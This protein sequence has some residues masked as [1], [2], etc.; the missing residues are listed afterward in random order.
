VLNKPRVALLTI[1]ATIVMFVGAATC[2][3]SAALDKSWTTGG[4]AQNK[5]SQVARISTLTSLGSFQAERLKIS[6]PTHRSFVSRPNGRTGFLTTKAP[7]AP[8]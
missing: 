8:S 1:A 5:G 3:G 4:Y 7:K 2:R 6:D